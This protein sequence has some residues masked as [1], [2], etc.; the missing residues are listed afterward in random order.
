LKSGRG[1][2]MSMESKYVSYH[3]FGDPCEV[4]T[5]GS[6]DIQEPS[7][8]EILVRM[9][10]RPINP[11]DLIPVRGAYSHRIKLP[12]VPGYEGVGV[13]EDI[14]PSVPQSFLGK[15][16]LP[17]RG[18]GTWQEIVKTSAELAVLVPDFIDDETACQLYINP[19]TAWII[20]TQVLALKPG[21]DLVVNAC[22][23][24][25]GR[26]FAQLSIVFGFR[27]IA[28]TRNDAHTCELLNLGASHVVNTAKMKLSETV[29]ELTQGRGATAAIDSVGGS[30]G[31]EL[32]YCTRPG[33]IVLSIGLLSGIPVDWVEVSKRTG[34]SAR[35][36]WLRHWIQSASIR[37]W[38]EAFSHVIKLVE[39]GRLRFM[40]LGARFD[41][42]DV[43]N[44]VRVA[45]APGRLGKVMLTNG[46]R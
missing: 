14:G 30:Y 40:T 10:I 11:S 5:I 28:V 29:M 17:L 39:E 41:L 27:L 32:A 3:Q 21:D 38:Q 20:C 31:E 7:F 22:G 9:T 37:T 46:D 1:G 35:M 26:I 44:A 43:K 4:L 34:V 12:A 45:D 13:V 25:I 33:D 6:R 18:E 36:F 42:N 19:V 8:G 2:K 16:V 23:S 24:S 15:R